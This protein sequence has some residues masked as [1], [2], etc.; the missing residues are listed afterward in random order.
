MTTVRQAE[1]SSRN[2]RLNA[3]INP[4]AREPT[5]W[6]FGFLFLLIPI[7]PAYVVPSG[8]LK[9]NG[10]P[11]RLI[12]V[13]LVGLVVL[14]FVLIRRTAR[15]ST[16]RPGVVLILIYFLMLLA[17]YG[18]GLSHQGTQ[19]VE[20]GKTRAILYLI[21]NVGVALYALTRCNSVRQRSFV[22]GCLAIGLVFN[23][24]VGLFQH[25]LQIDLHLLFQPPGFVL[26]NADRVLDDRYGAKRAFG[27][28]GHAIEFSVL[29]AVTVPLS[30]HF[31]RYALSRQARL[32]ALLAAVIALMAMP[33]G[34]S[35]SGVIALT[36]AFLVY[37]WAF[38]L[39]ELGVAFAVGA[40]ALLVDFAASPHTFR[41]LWET[42]INSA[43]DQS[44]LARIERYVQVSQTLHEHPLFGLGLGANP[45]NIYGPLDN[46]WFNAL[47]QGG[48]IGVLGM[49]I[50]AIGGI[51]GLAASLR[52][53]RTARERDQAYTIGAMFVGILASSYTFD[54]FSFQQATL[55]FFL[56][57]GLLW[58]SFRLSYSE[59]TATRAVARS[60]TQ[61]S[62]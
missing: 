37:M 44:V 39:R 51:F 15:S 62:T 5:P 7:L 34:V 12:A 61:T 50:L 55:V 8:P 58:S 47:V 49:V 6:L 23:C 43:E 27:T 46:E 56:L 35:R 59:T 52:V 25:T 30:I 13:G 20:A 21:G 22:L 53:A 42:I 2:R 3:S 40:F 38:K 33:A 45:S 17:V 9:S 4:G 11:A 36:A 14:G 16:L 60:T 32:L 18:V 48:I 29:A 24:V 1:G 28:S 31:A 26:N 54:L 19:L 10:S 57:F 41:A